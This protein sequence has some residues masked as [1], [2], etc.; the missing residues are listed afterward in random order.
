MV[1]PVH[2]PAKLAQFADHYNP[3]IVARRIRYEARMTIASPK[4]VLP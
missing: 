2:L 1:Q 4:A 3:R